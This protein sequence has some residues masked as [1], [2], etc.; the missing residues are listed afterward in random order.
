M[1]NRRKL[2]ADKEKFR[3]TKNEQRR[4][5]YKRTQKYNARPWTEEDDNKVLAHNIPDPKL[6][7]MIQRSVGAIQTR[8]SFLKS[9]KKVVEN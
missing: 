8:R 1:S 6:S 9:I 3:E 2:Y 4:R 5:Y 7:D